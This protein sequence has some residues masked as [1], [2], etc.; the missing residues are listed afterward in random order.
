MKRQS[1]RPQLEQLES[2]QLLAADGF[3]TIEFDVAA[4][5]ENVEQVESPI[6]IDGQRKVEGLDGL[7][8]KVELP[9]GTSRDFG[10][11]GDTVHGADD[12]IQVTDTLTYPWTSV[13]RLISQWPDG[14]SGLCSGTVINSFQVL[15]AGHCVHDGSDW[16]SSVTVAA[17]QNGS[18]QFYGVANATWYRSYTGWTNDQNPEHDWAMISLD[19]SIGD[20]TGWMGREVRSESSFDGGVGLNT[21]G[22][23][24]DL[25]G[26]DMYRAFGT[27]DSANDL[28]VW[29]SGHDG[30][31]T[32][33]GQ[34]GSSLYY[35]DGTNRYIN[36]IHAYGGTSL[37]SGTRLNNDKFDRLVTW[38]ND[39]ASQRPPND[40]ADLVDFDEWFDSDFAF[41]SSSSVTPGD[42]FSVTAYPRNNGTV[43]ASNYTVSFYASTNDFISSSDT[44]L[45]STTIDSTAPFTWDTATA[46]TTFPSLSAG[47]YYVGWI[48]DSGSTVSE[49]DN[50]NNTGYI[51]NQMLTV[52]AVA[53]DHGDDRA[54]AS[55]LT[56][57]VTASG[58]IN[59]NADHD[60]FRFNAA[61]GAQISAETTLVGLPDSIIT[62]L[63]ESTTLTSNDDGGVGLASRIDW[64]IGA[65]GTYY[66]D[67]QSFNEDSS[68]TY[69][70]EL[71]HIDDH[72]DATAG[73]TFAPVNATSGGT[74]EVTGDT[75][76]FAISATSG[77]DYVFETHLGSLSDSLIRLY[78]GGG[79]FITSNDD[80]GVG[81]ASRIDWSAPSS[82]T[83]FVEVDAFSTQAGTYDLQITE[84]GVDPVDGDFNNDGS[85]DCL[86]IDVLTQAIVQ[87]NNDPTL[88][89]SGDGTLSMA[90]VDLWLAEA[91]TN[92]VGAPFLPAD[93]TLD[94][95][96]DVSDFAVWNANK[97][98]N[99]SSWCAGDFNVD[100][101]V[102]VSDF[103]IWNA[104]KFQASMPAPGS[105]DGLVNSK[106][107]EL[108]VDFES[109]PEALVDVSQ[110]FAT[111]TASTMVESLH[112]TRQ[113][114]DQEYDVVDKI[115]ADAFN[116]F[117]LV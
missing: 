47:S 72:S 26:S 41:M 19:R 56:T 14:S 24:G 84:S 83:Y 58:D 111:P 107:M 85:Y 65:D 55:Q 67:V 38:I 80:G 11:A 116:D 66:V 97:F 113:L 64:T 8:D 53:D 10:D 40:R 3:Q 109:N 94:G 71:D 99:N 110:D 32:A 106:A 23:P 17:A 54:S 37:N 96:V 77:R 4:G 89:L 75:D 43:T 1:M 51:E 112:S 46:N 27:S 2:R 90:D 63:D 9:D 48:I 36:T 5:V 22:Y 42:S 20:F 39:D 73:A 86:D 28:R 61:A 70:L 102:D 114:D 79:T 44:F 108:D 49:F 68:G 100:G 31:D 18:E 91:G 81:L 115:F 59:F 50:S 88:D 95:V 98:T 92:N 87:G 103:A 57:D 69:T 117:A 60:F 25:G 15:T 34:S 62:L 76:Y 30:L 93:G 105:A 21:A 45:G 29:Y 16:A 13:T 6:A 35:F 12:R 52:N 78:D 82:G 74:L 104:N 33:G 7:F 101:V